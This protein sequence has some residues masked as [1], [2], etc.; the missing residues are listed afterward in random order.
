[1]A[2]L[3]PETTLPRIDSALPGAA[4]IEAEWLALHQQAQELAKLARIAAEPAQIT[5]ALGQLIANAKS[6]QRTLLSQ[7]IEDVAAMLGSGMAALATL[8]DRG[9]DTGAPA[10]ALWREFHAA[11]GALLAVLHINGDG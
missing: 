7:G 4:A 3:P 10:L 9:Q 5:P 8:A 11:R 6:W 2:T 1:M